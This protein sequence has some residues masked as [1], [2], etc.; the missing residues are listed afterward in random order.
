MVIGAILLAV[1]AAL[2]VFLFLP[3]CSEGAPQALI[4]LREKAEKADNIDERLP[5]NIQPLY[6]RYN[7][8][9]I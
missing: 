6:Y 8:F 3:R 2:L 9:F 7:F 4:K 5:R 1:L